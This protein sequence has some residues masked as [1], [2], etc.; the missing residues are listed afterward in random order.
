MA[1]PEYG[2]DPND[3]LAGHPGAL[4][5]LSGELVAAVLATRGRPVGRTADGELVGRLATA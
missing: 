4:R 2:G 5:P 1:S 3:P